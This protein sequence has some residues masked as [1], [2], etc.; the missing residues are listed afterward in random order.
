MSGVSFFGAFCKLFLDSNAN[1][2]LKEGARTLT[3]QPAQ[4][5]SLHSA[6]RS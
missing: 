2:N 3:Q 1:L 6:K 4:A 5:V